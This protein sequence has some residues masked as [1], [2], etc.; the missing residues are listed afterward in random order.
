[1]L[2]TARTVLLICVELLVATVATAAAG[3]TARPDFSGKYVPANGKGEIIQPTDWALEV[4]QTRNEIQVTETFRGKAVVNRYKL[5]G[6]LSPYTPPQG[7]KGTCTAR[8]KGMT[9][10]FDKH[11]I[12][13]RPM[14]EVNFRFTT[15]TGGYCPQI[16]RPLGWTSLL[17]AGLLVLFGRRFRAVEGDRE[18]LGNFAESIF[19]CAVLFR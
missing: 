13:R 12:F 19:D 8:F 3:N 7:G 10:I 18:W 9:L 1:M 16:Q 15:P 11:A 2:R 4:F 6:S 14:G 5:D 17:S